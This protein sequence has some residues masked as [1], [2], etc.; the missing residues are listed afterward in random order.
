MQ[1]V[2]LEKDDIDCNGIELDYA[3]VIDCA[4]STVVVRTAAQ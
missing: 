2:L 4:T 1:K 3:C